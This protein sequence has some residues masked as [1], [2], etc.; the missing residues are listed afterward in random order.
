[1][2]RPQPMTAATQPMTSDP[3]PNTAS[4]GLEPEIAGTFPLSAAQES[5]WLEEQLNPGS[6]YNM[7]EAWRL[8]GELDVRAL[9]QA[10]D[11]LIARHETLR[12]RLCSI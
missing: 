7:P 5:I 4:A 6:A 1:M 8:K 10:L 11:G 12:V 2:P 9:Q 3:H